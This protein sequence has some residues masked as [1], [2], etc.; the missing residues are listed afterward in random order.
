MRR[1]LLQSEAGVAVL[2]FAILAPIFFLLLLALIDMSLFFATHSIVDKSVENAARAVRL[3]SLQADKD[4]SNFRATLCQNLYFVECE[5]FSFSVEATDNLTSVSSKP[6]ID[7]EGQIDNPTYNP[8]KPEQFVVIT[9][10]YVYRFI[11]PWIGELLGD[12]GLSDPQTRA[13]V[14]FLVIKNEPY[15]D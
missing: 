13:I 3:G 7:K 1:S 11:I 12:D 10:V 8:G 9:I 15:P 2:E 6:K 4:G 14:S 5:K